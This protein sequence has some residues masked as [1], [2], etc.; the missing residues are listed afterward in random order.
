[1]HQNKP[2]NCITPPAPIENSGWGGCLAFRTA[3]ACLQPA[4]AGTRLQTQFHKQSE[5]QNRTRMCVCVC[6]CEWV[7]TVGL[8]CWA[9]FDSIH[10]DYTVTPSPN[11]TSISKSVL[12]QRWI[13]TR[14]CRAVHIS[15][16]SF[17]LE[18]MAHTQPILYNSTHLRIIDSK[19]YTIYKAQATSIL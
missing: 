6:T 15:T 4:S 7:R 13:S 2:Q 1:M 16:L 18:L 5:D 19:P 9:W 12:L 10:T 11:P 3:S 8:F 14:D 17:L